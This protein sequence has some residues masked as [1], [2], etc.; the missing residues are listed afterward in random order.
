[1]QPNSSN[2]WLISSN[3]SK[4][5]INGAFAAYQTITWG[6]TIEV[7]VDDLI[8]IYVSAPES[9]IK[10]RCVVDRVNVPATEKIGTEFWLKPIDPNRKLINIRLESLLDDDRLSLHSLIDGGLI[11]SAPQGP[12]KVPDELEQLLSSI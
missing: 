1:M 2:Q 6:L 10:Y 4:Y 9:K 3:S 8:Y 12:R 7:D 11:K 5:N